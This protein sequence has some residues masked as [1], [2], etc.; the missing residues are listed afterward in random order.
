MSDDCPKIQ[1]TTKSYNFCKE[2]FCLEKAGSFGE[3]S[4]CKRSPKNNYF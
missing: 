3:G 2:D 4:Y 1:M